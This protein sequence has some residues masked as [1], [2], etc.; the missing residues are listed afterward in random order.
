MNTSEMFT[1][2]RQ[3]ASIF[4]MNSC[5]FQEMFQEV[6]RTICEFERSHHSPYDLIA[7]NVNFK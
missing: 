2:I 7:I 5:D 6:N 4:R 3:N 1:Y